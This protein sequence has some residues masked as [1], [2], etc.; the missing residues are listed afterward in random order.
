MELLRQLA[1]AEGRS[2]GLLSRIGE[3]E[4]LIAD[5]RTRWVQKLAEDAQ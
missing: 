4:A 1:E 3:L 5:E 2:G